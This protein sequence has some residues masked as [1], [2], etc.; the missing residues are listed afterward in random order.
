MSTVTARMGGKTREGPTSRASPSLSGRQGLSAR[1]CWLHPCAVLRRPTDSVDNH[2]PAPG[3]SASAISDGL[4]Q[5]HPGPQLHCSV[6]TNPEGTHLFH[7]AGPCPEFYKQDYCFRMLRNQRSQERPC[8]LPWHCH[9]MFAWETSFSYQPGWFGSL[10]ALASARIFPPPPPHLSWLDMQSSPALPHLGGRD[11]GL[12]WPEFRWP[13]KPG[14][15]D[16]WQ[17]DVC[18]E[19]GDSGG[20]Q[21]HPSEQANEPV[22]PEAPRARPS[23]FARFVRA[24]RRCLCCIAIPEEE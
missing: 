12:G 7:P 10:P 3:P 1:S 16:S 18:S 8:H 11:E 14:S 22:V 21:D 20:E 2:P 24:V 5:E 23:R 15:S 9:D 17:E 13:S 4:C 19:A 6:F